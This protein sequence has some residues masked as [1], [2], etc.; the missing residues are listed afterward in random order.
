MMDRRARG[1][2]VEAATRDHLLRAGLRA[3]EAKQNFPLG[4]IDMVS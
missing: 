4:D 2:G 3:E 1:A